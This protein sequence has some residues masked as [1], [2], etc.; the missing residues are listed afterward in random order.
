MGGGDEVMAAHGLICRLRPRILTAG[1]GAVLLSLGVLPHTLESQATGAVAFV[2]ATIIDGNGGSPLEDG[3]L[4]VVG[5]QIQ[6]V[7]PRAQVSIPPGAREIDVSGKYLVPGFID[8]NTHTSL[9][10]AGETLELYEHLHLDLVKEAAQLH[11]K[12]GVTTIRDSYGALIPLK[13]TRD[14]I[15]RGEIVGPRMKV[16]GNIVGWGGPCSVSFS[17]VR[18][19]TCDERELEFNQAITQGVSGEELLQMTPDELRVAIQDYLALGPD[20]IRY[21]ATT[22]FTPAFIAFSPDAQ[23]VIVE[24]AHRRG[25]PVETHSTTVE[26][27]R[28]PVLAGVDILQHPEVLAREFPD[29]LV[30][31]IRER[32][33]ICGIRASVITGEPW[34]RHLEAE[35]GQADLTRGLGLQRSNAQR[36]IGGGCIPAVGN[37]NYLGQAPE[38]RVQAK[39]E[40][41]EPGIGTILAIKGL[42]E[43]GLTPAEAIVAATRNGAM[44]ARSLDMFG[45]LE[46]GKLAD[47]LVLDRNPLEDISNIRS[48]SLVM[49]EGAIVDHQALPT[50]PVWYQGR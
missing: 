31:L 2:G 37:D 17:M 35:G 20:H 15:E 43:L 10:R 16:A 22:H 12:H 44:A 19:E 36:L 6:A 47:L 13:E 34:Q 42:V 28:I 25:L 3:T 29:E 5:R 41:Q 23:R 38:L 32:E 33:I 27:M 49:K 40:A 9:Y 24:E 1:A 46:A 50:R 14:A 8:V 7:G 26:G 21:G 11:L 45:T 18:P 4:L 48:L 30:S 39:P